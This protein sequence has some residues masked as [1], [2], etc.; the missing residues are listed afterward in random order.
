MTNATTDNTAEE[1]LARFAEALQDIEA[2]PKLEA[3]LK[4]WKGFD[5]TVKRNG[6]WLLEG[7]VNYFQH[8][9]DIIRALDPSTPEQLPPQCFDTESIAAF[10]RLPDDAFAAYRQTFR[11]VRVRA[12]GP[13]R[14]PGR[15]Q[16]NRWIADFIH[17]RMGRMAPSDIY[18]EFRE[19]HPHENGDADR[20]RRIY[21]YYYGRRK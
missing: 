14:P 16:K 3:A 6:Q 4:R 20:L 9:H 15:P 21:R 17:E 11:G 13:P 18:K 2:H 12:C 10:F 5:F 1:L 19:H 7:F 8:V